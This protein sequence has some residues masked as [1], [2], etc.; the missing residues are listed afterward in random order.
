MLWNKAVGKEKELLE[1]V[2]LPEGVKKKEHHLVKQL[3][4]LCDPLMIFPSHPIAEPSSVVHLNYGTQNDI[5][6]QSMYRLY[7]KLVS[8]NVLGTSG[9]FHINV[10]LRRLNRKGI[11]CRETSV[12]GRMPKLL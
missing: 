2:D 12:L 4:S 6:N 7:N 10:W 5:S 8:R 1:H 9:V 11:R 3:G